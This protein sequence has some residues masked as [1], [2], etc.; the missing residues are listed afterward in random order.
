[1]TQPA[2]R[3]RPIRRSAAF[4][5]ILL[6]CALAIGS[7]CLPIVAVASGF[8]GRIRGS[9]P[10]AEANAAQTP[11][12]ISRPRG[13]IVPAALAEKFYFPRRESGSYWSPTFADVNMFEREF[14]PLLEAER[15]PHGNWFKEDCAAA[16]LRDLWGYT[17]QY[18]GVIEGGRRIIWVN[19]FCAYSADEFPY[20]QEQAVDVSDGGNCFGEAEFDPN[21]R[22]LLRL[23]CHG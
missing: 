5:V 1:M 18:V 22:R 11:R 23:Q 2:A 8:L 15:K 14:A 3:S 21:T 17:R 19:F 7:Y 12:V 16:V 4:W 9:R 20:W 10:S 6:M 13:V